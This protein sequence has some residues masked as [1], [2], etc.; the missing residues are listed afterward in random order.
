MTG[1]VAARWP[2]VGPFLK[3]A[4]V[5][6]IGLAVDVVVLYAMFAV[7]LDRFAGR[8]VSFFVAVTCTW[9]LNRT[10]TFAGRAG[11]KPLREWGMFVLANGTGAAANLLT[12]MAIMLADPVGPLWPAIATAAGSLSGL[13]LNFSA[14]ATFVFRGPA[15]DARAQQGQPPRI[16]QE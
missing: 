9:Y 5:G 8:M 15:G 4:S 14:S 11:A 13:L 3:F 16:P 10:F 6:T 7:G 1:W 2:T 12:Y